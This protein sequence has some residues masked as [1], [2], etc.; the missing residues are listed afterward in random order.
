VCQSCLPLQQDRA[1]CPPLVPSCGDPH[2]GT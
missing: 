2:D 1:Q